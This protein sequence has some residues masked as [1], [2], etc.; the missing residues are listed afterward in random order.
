M[1]THSISSHELIDPILQK[2]DTI[3]TLAGRGGQRQQFLLAWQCVGQPNIAPGDGNR[4]ARRN[5]VRSS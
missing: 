2:R 5:P 3:L 1:A 4:M